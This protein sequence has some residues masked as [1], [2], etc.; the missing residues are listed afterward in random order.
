MNLVNLVSVVWKL[1]L[2]TDIWTFP[3]KIQNQ[4]FY[5]RYFLFLLLL[6]VWKGNWWSRWQI[7]VASHVRSCLQS[8][9]ADLLDKLQHWTANDESERRFLSISLLQRAGVSSGRSAQSDRCLRSWLLHSR[10]I[11]QL[12]SQSY[13]TRRRIRIYGV[14]RAVLKDIPKLTPEKVTRSIFKVL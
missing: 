9:T 5:N 3:S 13:P 7:A 1:K 12:F 4:Y 11:I 8:R 2:S 14:F 10:L 6:K